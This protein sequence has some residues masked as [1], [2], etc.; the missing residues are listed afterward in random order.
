M[1]IGTRR[2]K[3]MPSTPSGKPC[4]KCCRDCSPS[5][6]M[7][8]P[9]SSW[10]FSAR[11]V[12]S[13]LPS[14]SA[15]ASRRQAGHNFF[16]SASQDGFG[17]LPAIVVSSIGVPRSAA[18]GG[19]VVEA[20]HAG[21]AVEDLRVARG[22]LPVQFQQRRIHVDPRAGLMLEIM[23]AVFAAHQRRAV[24]AFELADRGWDVADRKTDAA[25]E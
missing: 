25:I 6:T 4:T 2:A 17:R 14:A 24:L 11:S 12:A 7:S 22:D 16:G 19:G 15:S 21:A 3:S 8:M 23:K 5:L 18:E 10:I 13:R 9:Q 20:R 1:P